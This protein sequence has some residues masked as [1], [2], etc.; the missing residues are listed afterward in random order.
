MLIGLDGEA[1]VW[2]RAVRGSGMVPKVLFMTDKSS[3]PHLGTPGSGGAARD[4]LSDSRASKGSV[5]VDTNRPRRPDDAA[6]SDWIHERGLLLPSAKSE[7]V[8]DVIVEEVHGK[9]AARRH[10]T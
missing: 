4:P 2:N 7:L 5:Q 9:T 3:A 8:G 1:I 6:M 10:V